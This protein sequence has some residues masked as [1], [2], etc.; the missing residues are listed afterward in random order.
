MCGL[1]GVAGNLGRKEEEAF[2]TLLE[3]DTV[4]GPHSTGILFVN[5][6][7]EYYTVVKHVGTPWDLYN[8]EKL[9][10]KRSLFPKTYEILAGHNRAATKG[11]VNTDNAHPFEFDTLVGMHNGTLINQSLLDDHK[12]FEVDSENLFYHMDKHG[13]RDT[14]RKTHGAFALVWWGRVD[15]KLHFVRN[16]QRPLHYAFSKDNKTLFWASEEWVLKAA[17]DRHQIKYDEIKMLPVEQV[18]SFTIPQNWSQTFDKIITGKVDVYK[19]PLIPKNN[20]NTG[21]GS[22]KGTK[23]AF[24]KRDL[25]QKPLPNSNVT[26]E[27][28]IYRD[29][30]QKELVM[31][32]FRWITNKA[33]GVRNSFIEC[34]VLN[35]RLLKVRLYAEQDSEL[36]KQTIRTNTNIRCKAKTFNRSGTTGDKWLVGDLRTVE[37]VEPE[38]PPKLEVHEGG[39]NQTENKPK[40]AAPKGKQPKYFRTFNGVLVD[41]PT[42]EGLMHNGCSWCADASPESEYDELVWLDTQEFVCKGCQALPDVRWYL[43]EGGV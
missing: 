7:N 3:I 6:G 19:A 28:S 8:Q 43:E 21:G 23:G 36:W 22:T 30:L 39:K 37:L 12:N 40:G 18:F 33:V 25:G 27:D 41:K 42:L 5:K 4:R 13:L 1:V 32:P 24:G 35:N 31:K 9:Y 2:L 26:L 16:S 15:R 11:A 38:Q 29:N 20:Y 17:F 34:N 10:S 14:M